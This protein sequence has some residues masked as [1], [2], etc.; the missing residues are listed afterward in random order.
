[1]AKNGHNLII[2]ALLSWLFIDDI[3]YTNRYVVIEINKLTIT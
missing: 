1:L 3:Y 2:I